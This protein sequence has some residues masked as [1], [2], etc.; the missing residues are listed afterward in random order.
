MAKCRAVLGPD[1]TTKLEDND[2]HFRY[3]HGR[4]RAAVLHTKAPGEKR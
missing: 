4:L 1:I 3:K 2:F